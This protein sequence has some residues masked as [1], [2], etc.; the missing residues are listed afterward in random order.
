MKKIGAFLGLVLAVLMLVGCK[1]EGGS[2]QY[3]VYLTDAPGEFEHVYIDVQSVRIHTNNGGWITPS[4]FN[5]GVYDL[6]ELNNGIDVLLGTAEIPEGHVSQIRLILGENNSVVVDEVSHPLTTPSAHTSGLK[7]N[8]H[9]TIVAGESYSVWLDFD[10]G[11]SVVETGNGSYILKPVIRV[12][13]DLTN[14]I[15]KGTVT[16]MAALPTVYAIQNGDTLSAIPNADGYFMISGL[17]GMY[18]VHIVP[19]VEGYSTVEIDGVQVTFGQIT[20]LGVIEIP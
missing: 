19:S 12:F 6:L 10:A 5:A 8:V 20:D 1:K 11:Q 2:A 9:H 7:L 14:G 17:S 4:N 13:T 15:I 18:D 16:P 3:K